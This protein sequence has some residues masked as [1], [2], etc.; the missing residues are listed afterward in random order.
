LISSGSR[1]VAHELLA[2]AVISHVD[3]AVEGRGTAAL[4]QVEQFVAAEHAARMLAPHEQQV[5]FGAGGADAHALRAVQLAQARSMRQP[6]N[7]IAV[8]RGP[9]GAAVSAW[10]RCGGAPRECAP[11]ARAS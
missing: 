6:A 1:E 4:R 11:A 9:A 5:E 10:R 7:D 3:R 8:T 2:D